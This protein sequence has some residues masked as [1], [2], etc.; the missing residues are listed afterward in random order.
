MVGAIGLAR[1]VGH[2]AAVCARRPRGGTVPAALED[3]LFAAA[4]HHIGLAAPQRLLLIGGGASRAVLGTELARARG[5]LRGFNHEGRE[6][7]VVATHHPRM[8]LRQ[9]ALKAD[10]WRDLQLFAKDLPR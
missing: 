4:R 9:P 5:G 7:A 3:R 1:E 2:L 8:L 6:I 10:A